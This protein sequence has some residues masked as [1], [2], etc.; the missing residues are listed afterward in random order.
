MDQTKIAIGIAGVLLIGA[1]IGLAMTTKDRVNEI[2]NAGQ[3]QQG[4]PAAKQ[5][6]SGSSRAPIIVIAGALALGMGF[7]GWRFVSQYLKYK[8]TPPAPKEPWQKY[9]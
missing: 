4:T 7:V 8:S 2:E 5:D 6:D 3:P 9:T 1:L